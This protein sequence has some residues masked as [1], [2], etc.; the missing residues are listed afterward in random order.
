V[1]LPRAWAPRHSTTVPQEANGNSGDRGSAPE[2]MER[3]YDVKVRGQMELLKQLIDDLE[4][5]NA[6]LA[7]LESVVFKMNSVSQNEYRNELEY[8]RNKM[9]VHFERLRSELASL[10][11]A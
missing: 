4:N 3:N 5:A 8:Q 1:V 7:A 2:V 11:R 6:R 10:F 9:R